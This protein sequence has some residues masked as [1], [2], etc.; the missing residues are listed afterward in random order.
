MLLAPE[1]PSSECSQ[2]RCEGKNEGTRRLP[3]GEEAPDTKP[4]VPT[5]AIGRIDFATAEVQTAGVRSIGVRRRTPIEAVATPIVE[6]T[7]VVVASEQE[8]NR[9]S[10]QSTGDSRT[11]WSGIDV[12]SLY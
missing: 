2:E 5:A 4:A 9:V 11:R 1:M 7:I 8:A 6:R 3:T 12:V 10:L